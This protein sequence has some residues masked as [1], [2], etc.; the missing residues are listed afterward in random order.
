[1]LLRPG[2]LELR[3]F[4]A[5]TGRWAARHV[6]ALAGELVARLDEGLTIRAP[7][8]IGAPLTIRAPLTIGAPLPGA[9]GPEEP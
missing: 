9:P 8:T 5:L 7:L 3:G 4:L 6:P 1:M 2:G